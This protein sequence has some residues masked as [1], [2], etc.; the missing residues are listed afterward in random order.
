MPDASVVEQEFVKQIAIIL[1]EDSYQP[2]AIGYSAELDQH[3]R[4][5]RGWPVDNQLVKDL[6]ANPPITNVTVFAQPGQRNTTRFLRRMMIQP[7]QVPP[8]TMGAVISG[9]TVTF[10]GHGSVQEVISVAY[11]TTNGMAIRLTDTDT[12]QSVAIKFCQGG[13]GSSSNGVLTLPMGSR[14]SVAFGMDVT[15]LQEVHRQC[16]I[17]RV[18]IWATNPQLRDEFCS[19]I[20]PNLQALDRFFFPDGSCSGPV[21][22]AGFNVDDVPQRQDLWKRDLLYETEYPTDVKLVAPVMVLGEGTLNDHL[23][24]ADWTNTDIIGSPGQVGGSGFAGL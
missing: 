15:S 8:V 19:L 10:E 24:F 14:I 13:M 2:Y 4:L 5:M 12:P 17:W 21:I 20:D 23:F 22:G 3:F 18:T 1:G 11:N 6:Q 16:G 7:V 9:N